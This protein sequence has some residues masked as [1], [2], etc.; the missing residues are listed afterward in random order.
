[1]VLGRNSPQSALMCQVA[2]GTQHL[3]ERVSLGTSISTASA[4]VGSFGFPPPQREENQKNLG[5]FGIA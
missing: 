2:L 5:L 4:V 3:V 1:M